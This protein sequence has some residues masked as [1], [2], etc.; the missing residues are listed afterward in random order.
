MP[1][2]NRAPMP[3]LTGLLLLA[4]SVGAGAGAQPAQ[5]CGDRAA[6]GAH[7]DASCAAPPAPALPD[8]DRSGIVRPDMPADALGD[9]HT[10][11]P[12]QRQPWARKQQRTMALQVQ[13][14]QKK[15]DDRLAV[16]H[17]ENRQRCASALRVAAACGKFA[18]TF[19]CGEK[20]FQPIA[21]EAR[22]SPVA[23]NNASRHAMERC[24]TQAARRER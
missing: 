6:A 8:P 15:L 12:V 22:V 17:A 19:Y 13:A 21:P 23:M 18:G 4:V 20:G 1:D 14:R 9:W 11:E 7:R 16:Q 24:A 2:I 5:L 10:G 3:A